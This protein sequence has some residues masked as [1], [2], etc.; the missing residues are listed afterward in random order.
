[1]G[2][3]NT[4]SKKAPFLAEKHRDESSWL[5]TFLDLHEFP[6]EVPLGRLDHCYGYVA[7]LQDLQRIGDDMRRAMAQEGSSED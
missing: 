4:Q 5:D 7:R 1:M 2:S 3:R 6:D